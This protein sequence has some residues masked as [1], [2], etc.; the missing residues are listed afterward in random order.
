MEEACFYV[1]KPDVRNHRTVILT[2]EHAIEL[3]SI[4]PYDDPTQR[5]LYEIAGES[6]C[7]ARSPNSKVGH[8]KSVPP[9]YAQTIHLVGISGVRGRH[10]ITPRFSPV[11]RST[12]GASSRYCSLMILV[13]HP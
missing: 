10:R 5:V 8:G 2:R 3:A 1:R 6:L 7:E 4:A 13:T 9:H 12:S 11:E